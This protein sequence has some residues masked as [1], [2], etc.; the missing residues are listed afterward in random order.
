MATTLWAIADRNGAAD[1]GKSKDA[2][3]D[4]VNL[5][6]SKR[7]IADQHLKQAKRR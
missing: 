1:S 4:G 2:A 6:G 3:V 5:K 7:E